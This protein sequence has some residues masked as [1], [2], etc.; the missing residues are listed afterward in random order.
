MSVLDLLTDT[1]L[2]E[3]NEAVCTLILALQALDV[4][5]ADVVPPAGR[6]ALRRFMRATCPELSCVGHFLDAPDDRASA[7]AAGMN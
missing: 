3:L 6:A 5:W 1:E 2:D 7:D 4:D